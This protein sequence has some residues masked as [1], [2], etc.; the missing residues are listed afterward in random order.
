[1]PK[2]R[3]YKKGQG[4]YTRIFTF[5]GVMLV[6]VVG[7]GL[8]SGKLNGYEVTRMPALRFGIPT[9][10]AVLMGMLMFW[11]VNRPSTADFFIATESEMKKVS[12]SSRKEI[13]GSTK[14]VIVFTFILAVL[15]YTVDV[16]FAAIFHKLN[17]MG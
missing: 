17:V 5:L 14:V 11:L 4:K 6:V 16:I 7:A 10:L 8:L 1:M 15:L 2:F 3:I 13:I 9:C 12:W